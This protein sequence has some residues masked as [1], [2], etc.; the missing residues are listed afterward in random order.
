M[1]VTASFRSARRTPFLQVAK[2]AIA[3]IAAWLVAGA[4]VPG[5][6]PVFAAIAA[7]LVVQPSL[8]QSLTRAL[9]RSVGVIAGVIVASALGIALGSS[10]WVILVT[11]A[12]ALLV[13]WAL[14]LTPGA[15]N[16][17]AI[18]AIL[19]LALGT[20]TP[21]YAVDRVIETLIGALIGLIVNVLLV[22]PVVVAPAQERIE[23]LGDELTA[24]LGRLADALE[25]PQ[26]PASLEELLLQAR[27]MRPMRDTAE[28]ALSDATD[29]LALNPRGR[30]HRADLARLESLLEVF[31][32][33]MTQVIG[34][35]RAAYDRYD[36]SI[37]DEPTVRAI[38]DQLRRAAHDVHLTI[39]RHRSSAAARTHEPDTAASAALE[40]PALTRPLEV[41]APSAGH[42]ILVGSLLVDLHRI[43]EALGETTHT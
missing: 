2:S 13:A 25:S 34:M 3:T 39:V 4:L 5:P 36:P 28:A 16:Q 8:N 33:I 35:T 11:A 14:K 19:V 10:T 20:A 17:V 27:L 21:L 1:R 7:L 43:H 6:P 38:A 40:P 18:S 26:T 24:A 37:A 22:P 41:G 31:T 15:A 32:P 30:R 12:V 42:W 9:E 29:S 23:A